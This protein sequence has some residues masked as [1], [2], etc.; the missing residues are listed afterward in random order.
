MRRGTSEIVVA[1]VLAT[2]PSILPEA[3]FAAVAPT[4]LRNVTSKWEST[5]PFDEGVDNLAIPLYG[6]IGLAS[7][8]VIGFSMKTDRWRD[9]ARFR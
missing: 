5:D 3:G 1:S 7:G 4:R 8:A 2:M 9:V 6:S